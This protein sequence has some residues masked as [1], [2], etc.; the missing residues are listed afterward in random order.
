MNLSK[1]KNIILLVSFLIISFFVARQVLIN[2]I[3]GV[4]ENGDCERF[5]VRL[6]LYYKP[7][8]NPWIDENFD[9]YFFNYVI[10]EYIFTEPW[11]TGFRSSHELVGKFAVFLHDTFSHSEIFNI[12]YMGLANMSLYLLGVGLLLFNLKYERLRIVLPFCIFGVFFFTDKEIVQFLNSFYAEAGSFIYLLLYFGLNL[13]YTRIPK[14]SK[15]LQILILLIDLF[16]IFMFLNAKLQNILGIIPMSILF[17]TKL[18]SFFNSLFQN[19]TLKVITV[20]IV[21]VLFVLLPNILLFV[22]NSNRSIAGNSSNNSLVVYNVIMMEML[23][24]SDNPSEHLAQMGF[25]ENEVQELLGGVGLN[26]YPKFDLF[27]K[28]W[29]H[30]DREAQVMIIIREPKILPKLIA[31]Q[32]KNLF[33]TLDYGNFTR[34]SNMDPRAISFEFS[35]IKQVRETFYSNNFIFFSFILLFLSIL[36]FGKIRKSADVYSAYKY[37]VFLSLPTLVALTFFTVILADSG[38]E[39]VKHFFLTNLIF[40]C[41]IFAVCYY[42]IE[43]VYGILKKRRK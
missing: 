5:F 26:V 40:D 19:K 42:A 16:L 1:Y 28:Y 43:T 30:F 20:M 7:D 2:P 41:V 9:V 3:I 14:T 21:S 24:L 4:A 37:F 29:Q 13:L 23:N 8:E 22:S 12:K 39:I 35:N 25:Q 31:L 10:D 32:S 6:G 36:L 11:E 33:K 18:F 34:S 38:H 17:G 27:N 15:I